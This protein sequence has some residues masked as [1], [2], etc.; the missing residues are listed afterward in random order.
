MAIIEILDLKISALSKR[1]GQT[2]AR[3]VCVQSSS[4]SY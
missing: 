3:L 1:F 2:R 4:I